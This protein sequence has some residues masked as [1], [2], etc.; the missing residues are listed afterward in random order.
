MPEMRQRDESRVRET[1]SLMAIVAFIDEADVIERILRHLGLWEGT[2]PDTRAPT[3]T[4]KRKITY[5]PF[6][7]DFPTGSRD[8]YAD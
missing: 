5:E 4:V 1:L 7:D 2:S 8:W 6:Y 3:P